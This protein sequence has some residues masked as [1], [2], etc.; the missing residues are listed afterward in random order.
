ML[1][2]SGSIDTITSLDFIGNLETSDISLRGKVEM[3]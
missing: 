1:L 2:N 3:C